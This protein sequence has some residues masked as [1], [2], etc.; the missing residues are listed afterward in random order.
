MFTPVDDYIKPI[1][2]D[3][4][5]LM[6]YLNARYNIEFQADYITEL[7]HMHKIVWILI[8]WRK[9]LDNCPYYNDILLNVL[10]L[11]HVSVNKDVNIM[12]YL[13]RK[14]IESFLRF[15]SRYIPG[16]KD[17]ANVSEAFDLVLEN[18]KVDEF[19][20]DNWSIIKSIYSECCK[21]VHSNNTIEFQV[22]C[23]CL[24]NYDEYYTL[25]ELRDIVSE[26]IKSTRCFCNILIAYDADIFKRMAINDQVIIRDFIPYDNLRIIYTRL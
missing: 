19:K 4:S 5:D 22:A 7:K 13:L 17:V 12:N 9:Y 8:I 21:T 16:A 11:I 24:K 15:A 10:S 18:S 26:W 14:S 6:G 3:F 23:I 25:N 20:H 2:N 1:R